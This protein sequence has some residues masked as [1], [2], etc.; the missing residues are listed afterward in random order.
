MAGIYVAQ[1]RNCHLEV[2]VDNKDSLDRAIS[3]LDGVGECWDG[4]G[5][6]LVQVSPKQPA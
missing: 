4:R 1:C 6:D 5:H 3:A 2:T